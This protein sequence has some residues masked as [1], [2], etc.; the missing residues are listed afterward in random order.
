[1]LVHP[2]LYT[3]VP[4]TTNHLCSIQVVHLRPN[5]RQLQPPYYLTSPTSAFYGQMA[6]D[7][8]ILGD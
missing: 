5:E 4:L 1:M 2:N 3:E 7:S 8:S 6:V